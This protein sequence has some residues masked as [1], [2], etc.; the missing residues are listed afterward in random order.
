MKEIARSFV[1]WPELTNEIEKMV[2]DCSQCQQYQNTLAP[3]PLHPWEWPD[4]PWMR[5]HIDH[6]GPFLWKQFL[7]VVD[8]HS[9]WLEVEMVP[10][11]SSSY[12]LQKLCRIFVTHGLPK[13]IVSDNGTCF[14]SEEFKEF[15]K[16]TEIRQVTAAPYH[17]DTNRLAE[18]TVQT[19]K[20]ALKKVSKGKLYTR[21]P[22]FLFN[23]KNTPHTTTGSTPA[24]LLLQR[25]P[26]SLLTL[27]RPN[28][29][30]RVHNKQLQQERNRYT[31]MIYMPK[32]EYLH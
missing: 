31:S 6:A 23:Y 11:T 8:A 25:Q 26:Q 20:T 32:R 7:I 29:A 24:K 4:Q 15:T 21:L 9:K 28:M 14:T 10:S 12:T 5:L 27:I 3:S 2:R 22:R 13:I 19:F 30:G 18:R 16:R 1:W 17:P